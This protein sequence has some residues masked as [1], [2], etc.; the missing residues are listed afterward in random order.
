MSDTEIGRSP[1]TDVRLMV[2]TFAEV[3]ALLLAVEAVGVFLVAAFD[4]IALSLTAA[5]PRVDRNGLVPPPV[6]AGIIIAVFGVGIAAAAYWTYRS[7]RGVEE[8]PGPEPVLRGGGALAGILFVLGYSLGGSTIE[9]LVSGWIAELLAGPVVMIG[10]ALG[11]VRHRELSVRTRRPG[12][13]NGPTILGAVAVAVLAGVAVLLATGPVFSGAA[14][15]GMRPAL[16]PA[17]AVRSLFTAGIALGVGYALVYVGAIQERVRAWGN[18]ATAVGAVTTLLAVQSWASVEGQLLLGRFGAGRGGGSVVTWAIGT[19]GA[20]VVA[21]LATAGVAI[22]VHRSSTRGDVELTPLTVGTAVGGGF[23]IAAVL[24]SLIRGYPPGTAVAIGSLAFVAATA[25]V[26]YHRT[27]SIWVP[28]LV[29]GTY[30]L[31]V[32]SALTAHVLGALY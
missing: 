19:G 26:S 22:A 21:V 25:A 30:F 4:R 7:V 32:D 14:F 28:A 17:V 31:L 1:T 6:A 12:T 29:F 27:D 16:T 8:S 3:L 24:A 5:G 20:V 13:E 11:Y 10:I 15:G 23:A 2:A 18:P 9:P